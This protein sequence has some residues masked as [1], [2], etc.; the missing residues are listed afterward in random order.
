MQLRE[1]SQEEVRHHQD[2][3]L[4]MPVCRL[5]FIPKPNGL[6]PIVNMS[7]SMGTRAFGRKKQVTGLGP[8]LMVGSIL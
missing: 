1:L 5:R 3:W 7:Y 4:A 6:R 2:T 8:V